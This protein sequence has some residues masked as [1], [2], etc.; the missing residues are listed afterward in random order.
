MPVP[1]YAF[2]V[3][4]N[5]GRRAGKTKEDFFV[6]EFDALTPRE[7]GSLD[8][9]L[10]VIRRQRMGRSGGSISGGRRAGDVAQKSLF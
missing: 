5:I 3:H 9:D 10:E 7:A 4:T 6:E 1:D 2:D 8:P